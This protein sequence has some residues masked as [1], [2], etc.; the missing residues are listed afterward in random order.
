MYIKRLKQKNTIMYSNKKHHEILG[1]SK[2]FNF[3]LKVDK[4]RI[5]FM[6]NGWEFQKFIW[7]SK[8]LDRVDV[9]QIEDTNLALDDFPF[10]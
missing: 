10:G 1:R 4:G 7:R 2:E 5:N 9:R 8:L 6:S 3:R